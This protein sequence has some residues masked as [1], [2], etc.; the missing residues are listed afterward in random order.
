MTLCNFKYL[1]HFVSFRTYVKNSILD[2]KEF[3][4]KRVAGPTILEKLK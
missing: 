2:V 3:S 1:K 4:V